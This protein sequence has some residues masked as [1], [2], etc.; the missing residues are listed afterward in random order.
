MVFLFC[1]INDDGFGVIDLCQFVDFKRI[2]LSL[3]YEAIG[4]IASLTR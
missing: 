1:L 4:T 2:H 3:L